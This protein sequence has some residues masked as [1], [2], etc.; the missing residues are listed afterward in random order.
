MFKMFIFVLLFLSVA[1]ENAYAYLDFGTGSYVLQMLFASF[2]GIVVVMKNHLQW[3]KLL[4][5]RKKDVNSEID[6]EENSIDP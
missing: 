6:N 1:V 3:V 4:F 5:K 2:I